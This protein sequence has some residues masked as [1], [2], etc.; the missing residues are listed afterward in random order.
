M[1]VCLQCLSVTSKLATKY[2]ETVV[3]V[4]CAIIITYYEEKLTE[5]SE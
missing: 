3:F 5:M 1:D 2:N 4:Y